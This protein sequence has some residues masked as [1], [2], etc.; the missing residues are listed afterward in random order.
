M[1]RRTLGT[2]RHGPATHEAGM[3]D[4]LSKPEGL[5]F[6]AVARSLHEVGTVFQRP[7]RAKSTIGPF[8]HLVDAAALTDP[9]QIRASSD[10]TWS[11]SP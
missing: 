9:A 6:G 4:P 10:A 7:W 1:P 11:A 2:L 3:P 8:V 5:R